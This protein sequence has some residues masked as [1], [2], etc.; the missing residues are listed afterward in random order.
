MDFCYINHKGEKIDFSDFPYM[1]QEGDLLNWSFTYETKEGAKRDRT[2][3][4]KMAAKEIPV[5]IAVMCDYTVP[6]EKRKG[7]WVKAVNRLSDVVQTDILSGTDGT[8]YA[9]SGE[10]LK[11]KMIGSEKTDWRMGLPIMFHTLTILADYPFWITEKKFSFVAGKENNKEEFLDYPYNFPY[12][13]AS[14]DRAIGRLDN[15]HY[16]DAHFNM[17][18]YGPVVNPRILIGGY[19]YEV[20]TTVAKNE[21]L[22]IDSRAQTVVRTKQ[23]GTKINENDSR[24]KVQSIF[25]K[26]PVGNHTVNWSGEYG[27]DITLFQERSEPRWI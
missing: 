25:R 4:Y 17:I 8:L 13:Y 14:N 26:I 24:N 19:P 21:Y 9:S 6:F 7:D 16:T 22:V 3:N 1:F 15:D 12:D 10:Y 5:K 27:I 23:D 18:I 20:F 11:C 2:G